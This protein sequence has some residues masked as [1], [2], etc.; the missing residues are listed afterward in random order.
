[1]SEFG[2]EQSGFADTDPLFPPDQ[3]EE[4]W[5]ETTTFYPNASA[6]DLETS[7]E[8]KS[9]RIMIK[10]AGAGKPYYYLF[11][12]GRLTGRLRLNPKLIQEIKFCSR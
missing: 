5:K 1:M 10:M 2:L 3:R 8:P 4:S 9:K 11:T 6:I 12:K 7:Y